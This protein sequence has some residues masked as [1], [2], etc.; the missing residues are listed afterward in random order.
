MLFILPSFPMLNSSNTACYARI[1]PK[2]AQLCRPLSQ[3]R[4]RRIPK[5][6]K[7]FPH[8]PKSHAGIFGLTLNPGAGLITSAAAG[9]RSST[10]DA[11]AGATD[12]AGAGEVGGDAE[13]EEARGAVAGIAAV[14]SGKYF[15]PRQRMPF[16]SRNLGS[17]CVPMTWRAPNMRQARP[18]PTRQM[19]GSAVP[20]WSTGS[21]PCSARISAGAQGLTRRSLCSGSTQASS[22]FHEEQGES[23]VSPGPHTHGSVSPGLTWFHQ[24]VSPV[25]FTRD[26]TA[27][28]EL[29][30]E[31]VWGPARV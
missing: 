2:Y 15:S 30:R 4:D 21:I 6:A 31:R 19:S 14:G 1:M 22:R 29:K 25:G 10:A 27:H 17:K 28:V 18:Y 11:S 20:S 12:V 3:R 8:V 7:K 13:G 24:L 5:N 9:S 16:N 26:Q 23:M